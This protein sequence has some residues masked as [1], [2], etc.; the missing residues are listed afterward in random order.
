MTA[1]LLTF[2]G[3]LEE[4]AFIFKHT[5]TNNIKPTTGTRQVLAYT[6]T[7]RKII[8]AMFVIICY[9]KR[10]QQLTAHLIQ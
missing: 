10:R 3:L 5:N 4:N 9:F 1:T 8:M 7:H 2:T 6:H